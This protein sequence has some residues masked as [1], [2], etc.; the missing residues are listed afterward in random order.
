MRQADFIDSFI[1][2]SQQP[3]EVVIIISI[4]QKRKQ[5]QKVTELHKVTQSVGSRAKIQI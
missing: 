2:S 4:I 1:L 5:G 3:H